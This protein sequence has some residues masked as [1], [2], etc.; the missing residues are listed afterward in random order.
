MAERNEALE[1]RPE[2]VNSDPYGD[3]W[4]F[5]MQVEDPCRQVEGLLD[6]EADYAHAG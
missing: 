3:G 4:M 2:L 6:A 1:T 5:V